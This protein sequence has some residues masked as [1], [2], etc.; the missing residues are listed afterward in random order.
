MWSTS[1]HRFFRNSLHRDNSLDQPPQNRNLCPSMPP[2]ASKQKRLAEKA[3]K[4]AS[5]G[6][7]S[8][9]SSTAQSSALGT[10]GTAG[11]TAA[12]TEEITTSMAKLKAATDRS[13]SG[14][15]TSD[16]QSRDIQIS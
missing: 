8:A 7:S 3:A 6:E 5:K 12:S 4:N 16:V 15:L 2:S 9:T 10:P 13:G 11:S 1:H 14:V